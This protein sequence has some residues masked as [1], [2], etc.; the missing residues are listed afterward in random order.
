MMFTFTDLLI[1]SLARTLL[2]YP[3]LV[4]FLVQLRLWTCCVYGPVV[5]GQSGDTASF[6]QDYITLI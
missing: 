3:N 5:I 6:T 2:K 4:V 1:F